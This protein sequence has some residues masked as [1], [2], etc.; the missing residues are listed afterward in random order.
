MQN[1][2]ELPIL[3]YRG[4]NKSSVYTGRPQGEQARQELHLDG[5]DKDNL[6]VI[7]IVP[8][9]TTTITPSF[10]L[11]LLFDSIKSLGFENYK[12]KYSFGFENIS[13]EIVKLLQENISEGERNALNTL[14]GKRGY[15]Q[16]LKK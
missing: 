13:N 5:L 6:P 16:F 12:N 11:G 9:G 7:F 4:G 3:K 8:E 1:S 10:F 15:A 14:K 2:H